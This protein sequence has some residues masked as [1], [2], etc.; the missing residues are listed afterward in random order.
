MKSHVMQRTWEVLEV[1]QPE[2]Q[3]T[4]FGHLDEVLQESMILYSSW[5]YME[6]TKEEVG[7]HPWT[8]GEPTST[9][10]RTYLMVSQMLEQWKA[11]FLKRAGWHSRTTS[12][13]LK[14]ST[15]LSVR[16]NTTVAGY[17]HGWVRSSWKISNREEKS[18]KCAIKVWQLRRNIEMLSGHAEDA[19]MKAK[20]H[21]N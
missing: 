13:K 21:W 7:L 6:E 4:I 12:S 1:L 15:S 3:T 2:L 19:T 10:S 17:L 8:S 18:M 20:A 5:T 11:R 16:S 9:S 14:I